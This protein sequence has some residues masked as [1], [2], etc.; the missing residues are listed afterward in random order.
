MVGADPELFLRD[1][2]GNF[3]PSVGLIG[4]SKHHPRPI[5]DIGS[6]I[7]EDNVTVEFNIP[8]SKTKDE[9]IGNIFNVIG[10][11]ER[12]VGHLGLTLDYSA[13]AAFQPKHLRSEQARL[14]GCEPDLNCWTGE[15]N[16]RPKAPKNL[17]SCGG[18]VHIGWDNPN[19]DQRF[20]VARAI[21]L[22]VGSISALFDEDTQRRKIYGK[23]GACRL[24]H[25]GVEHRTS[26]NYWTKSKELTG[27]VF[28]QVQKGIE[29]VRQEKEYY[30]GD[31]LL[32][33]Q[34]INLGDKKLFSLLNER[35]GIL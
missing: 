3:F 11:L 17:R 8:P 24:K 20:L 29:F 21:D 14:F 31:E 22:F 4:G 32:I 7:L 15:E 18:H 27:L 23:A 12:E 35:Y 5:D 9:F 1:K 19:G 26:S 16:P 10:F 2:E 34:C 6:F 33:Q 30:Q 25:Y 13:S 28:D